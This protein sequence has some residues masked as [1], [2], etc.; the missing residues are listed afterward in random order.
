MVEPDWMRELAFWNN[1]RSG[2]HYKREGPQGQ[3][4]YVS[5][6]VSIGRSNRSVVSCRLLFR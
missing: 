6:S 2:G 5:C 4:V 1:R 3:G